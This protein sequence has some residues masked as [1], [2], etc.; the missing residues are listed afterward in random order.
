MEIQVQFGTLKIQKIFQILVV[1]QNCSDLRND[2]KSNFDFDS[3][4]SEL[5]LSF[6][7]K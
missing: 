7:L 5:P 6:Y 3:F 4:Y 2:Q 1:L